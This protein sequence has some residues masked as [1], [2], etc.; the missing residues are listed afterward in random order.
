MKRLVFAAA[1]ALVCA[2][3]PTQAPEPQPLEA[4]ALPVAD[5][6][7]NR[8][9]AL[10]DT[11]GRW[12]SS[13]GAWCVTQDADSVQYTHAGAEAEL[14]SFTTNSAPEIWPV[15]VRQAD[16]SVLIG[17]KW[18]ASTMY[19]GGG[20]QASRVTF[21]KITPGSNFVPE[22]LTVPV[23]SDIMIRACFG[24]EDARARREACHDEY[25]FEGQ[26]ALDT[27]NAT[28]APRFL[29]STLAT[30]FPGARAR[31]SDSTQEGPLQESDLVTATD[32][33]CTYQRTLTFNG[34]GYDYDT[35]P[36]ECADYLEP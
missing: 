21:Y 22:V 32:A 27:E 3:A 10:T 11:N 7:G 36:P 16:E 19:S 20:A 33:N 15:I 9:E 31:L 28:G 13:D 23:A 35:P 24:E 5:A 34:E 6:A 18:T 17:L 29:L 25:A 8:M 12:C 26:L 2:C 30:S 14:L 4:Q 1:A